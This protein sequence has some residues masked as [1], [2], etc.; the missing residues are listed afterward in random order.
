M[1][2]L[3]N[4]K[5]LTLSFI[6]LALALFIF[7]YALLKYNFISQQ[8]SYISERYTGDNGSLYLVYSLNKKDL[9]LHDSKISLSSRE[10]I[11]LDNEN[12]EVLNK[13]KTY[14]IKFDINNSKKEIICLEVFYE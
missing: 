8:L 12:I 2:I 3:F 14:D 9:V 6:L 7:V 5:I 1:K 11:K 4:N 13:C 10:Y